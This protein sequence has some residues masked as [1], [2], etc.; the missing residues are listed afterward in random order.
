MAAMFA[1]GSV[2]SAFGEPATVTYYGCILH[3]SP[4]QSRLG[5]VSSVFGQNETIYGVNED[6]P[7]NCQRGDTAISWNQRGPAG[8]TGVTGPSGETGAAGPVGPQGET[9][10]SGPAGPAGATGTDGSVGPS[11]PTG[12]Q[13]NAGAQG[14]TGVTGPSGPTGPGFATRS[15]LV[16][17]DGVS[18]LPPDAT[19]SRT[20]AG[21]YELDF[22]AGTFPPGAVAIPSITPL[23]SATVLNVAVGAVGNDGSVKDFFCLSADSYFMYTITIQ[24]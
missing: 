24:Q 18:A 7:A 11:G 2:V 3:A 9:G 19:T 12:L 10:P 21:C 14:A 6:G 15:G 4:S 5:P 16:R 23:S 20:S 8:E 22:P 13:G 17:D 1:A